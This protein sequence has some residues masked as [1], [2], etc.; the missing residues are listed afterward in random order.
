MAFCDKLIET[1]L[2]DRKPLIAKQET[3][4]LVEG[5][6]PHKFYY[7][8]GLF[9]EGETQN[10]NGRVY[11]RDEIA[12]AV[13][14]LNETIKS[15]GPIPGELDHPCFLDTTTALTTTG[16]KSIT[17]IYPGEKVYS[18]DAGGNIKIRDVIERF[19][20]DFDGDMIKFYGRSINTTVTPNHKMVIRDRSGKI[21][22]M[23]ARDIKAKMDVG[24]ARIKK[25]S[26]V[27]SAFGF[28]KDISDTIMV[29]GLV[30]EPNILAAFMGMYLSEGWCSETTNNYGL[31]YLRAK[32]CQNVG[33]VCDIFRMVLDASPLDYNEYS[34]END[35]GNTNVIFEFSKDQ[36][37]EFDALLVVLGK[38]Y[39]KY[40]PNWF[41][42]ICS[43]EQAE[44]F[45]DHFI[46]GDGRGDRQERSIK[47]DCFS[48]SEKL[49]DGIAH[50][51]GI[52][53]IP[54]HTFSRTTTDDYMFAGRVIKAENKRP[55][56]FLNFAKTRGI[57][58]DNR[59][60]QVTDV[61][62]KGKVYCIGVDVDHTF[63]ARDNGFTFWTG[64]SE[65]SI[66]FDRIAVAITNMRMDGNNGIGRMRVIPEGLGKIVEGAIKAGIQVGVSSRGTG[67]VDGQGRVT[68]FDIVTI[69]AV[70]NPSAPNAYPSASLAESLSQYQNGAEAMTLASYANHDPRAQYYLEQKLQNL[71]VDM[72]DDVV[73]RN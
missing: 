69:D 52:A 12:A 49:I 58:L 25:C 26:I 47:S 45:I 61:A 37:Q 71:F 39:E 38:C 67:N 68:D 20:Y 51:S 59:F 65:M 40:V 64:N 5:A 42:D 70:I 32:I 14:K 24:D 50:L 57:Y 11:P 35:A 19:E 56:W 4:S 16:W 23:T 3:E 43:T 48:T 72:R 46:M 8:E 62:H 28:Q 18:I 63:L 31:T 17:N 66:N 36:A 53:G 10:L 34:R 73:W 41:I 7:L 27:R 44:I 29:G 21:S 2:P 60:L 30:W 9:L 22:I 55:L 13:D 6:S 33:A 15:R 1:I 54:T